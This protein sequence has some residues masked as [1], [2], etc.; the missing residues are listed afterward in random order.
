MKNRPISPQPIVIH[1]HNVPPRWLDAPKA[2]SYLSCSPF[3]VEELWRSGELPYVLVGGK[4]VVEK[5][6]LDA[7]CDKQEKK[8]GKLR[9][10]NCN[11]R[12]NRR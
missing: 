11:E 5:A 9:E 8:T 7:W 6:D 4:R 1:I 3:M 10:P 2:A 12:W